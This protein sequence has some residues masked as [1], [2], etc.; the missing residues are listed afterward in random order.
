MLLRRLGALAVLLSAAPSCAA[1][2]SDCMLPVTA[3]LPVR[4]PGDMA[5]VIFVRRDGGSGNIY[6]VMD[7]QKQ[8]VGDSAAQSN[9][10]VTLP[11]GDHVFVAWNN[12]APSAN[13]FTFEVIGAPHTDAPDLPR[14]EPLRATLGPG[15]LYVV[16]VGK[17]GTLRGIPPERGDA[18]LAGTAAYAPDAERGRAVLARSPMRV[19]AIR[20]RAL[21]QL[22]SYRYGDVALHT[23]RAKD[24]R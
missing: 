23:L 11:P 19:E 10:V 14:L 8:F 7:D 24:G 6:T 21:E 4:A 15:K 2:R 17:D 9:F 18:V 22:D 16:E 12:A 3:A 13:A 1:A 5:V 20:Q